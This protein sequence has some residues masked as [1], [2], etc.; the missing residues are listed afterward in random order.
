MEYCNR[1]DVHGQSCLFV[2]GI[3]ETYSDDY[4][5]DIFEVH[6]G[7]V[8]CIRVPDEVGKPNG[9]VL[10]QYRDERSV[11]RMD[12]D[13]LGKTFSPDDSNASC[14]VTAI[15]EAMAPKPEEQSN[16]DKLKFAAAVAGLS[17]TR[18]IQMLQTQLSNLQLG[19]DTASDEDTNNNVP[20][21]PQRP[22]GL[23]ESLI[24]PPSVQRVIVEH[25]I[26][27]ESQS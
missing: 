2:S 20:E 27:T 1:Y 19:G 5:I 18:L 3:D 23:D 15:Q 4:I 22:S 11:A 8:K 9:R 12:P 25:I 6:G 17:K 14:H 10:V 21:T 7:I 16:L 24:N 13:F 26:K